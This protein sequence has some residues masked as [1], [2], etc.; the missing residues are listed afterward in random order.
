MRYALIFSRIRM[1]QKNLDN[2]RDFTNDK[3]NQPRIFQEI[4]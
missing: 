3:Y 4:P 2:V 1:L